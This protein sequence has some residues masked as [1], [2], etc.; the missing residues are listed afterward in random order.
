MGCGCLVLI[1]DLRF[2][3]AKPKDAASM[4]MRAITIYGDFGQF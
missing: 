2:K 4:L 3:M 1:K